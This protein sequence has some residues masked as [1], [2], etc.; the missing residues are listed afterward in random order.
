MTD[1]IDISDALF[2]SGLEV[3]AVITS[4]VNSYSGKVIFRN[5]YQRSPLMDINYQGSN[6]IAMCE[7]TMVDDWS[8]IATNTD[9]IIID[10]ENGGAAFKIREVKPAKPN[11]TILELSYD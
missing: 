4:G 6:P 9:T 7:F 1:L 8:S 2:N 10:G 3:D 11:Y 5:Q